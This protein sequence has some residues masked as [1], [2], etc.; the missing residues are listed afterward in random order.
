MNENAQPVFCK[1]YTVPYG[2]RDAV[3]KELD[4]LVEND[5]LYP[6]KHSKIASPIVIVIKSNGSIRICVD[7][8]RTINRFIELE[9]YPLPLIDDIFAN[10]SKCKNFCVLD[11]TGAYQQLAVSERSQEFLTINTHKGLYR[12]KRLVFGVASAPA[13]FQSFMDELLK[14]LENVKCYFD[15][16]CIGGKDFDECKRNLELVLDRFEKNNVRVNMDKCKFYRAT[17]EY[18]GHIISDGSL[19]P[20]D[21]KVEAVLNA[22]PP[23]NVSQLQSF[24]GMIN[25]YAKF[26]PNLSSVLFPLYGLLKKGIHFDWNATHNEAFEKC[27]QL[28]V[29]NNV[30][31]LYDPSKPIIISCD[32]SPYG[33]GCVLSQIF[34]KIEKPVLFASSTLSPAEKNY[35]QVHREA[36]AVVFAVKK[37]HKYVYGKDSRS[38]RIVKLL[39]RFLAT[40]IFHRLLPL[41]C[42]VG[43]FF[44]R[45]INTKWSTKVHSICVMRMGCLDCRYRTS[46]KLMVGQLIYLI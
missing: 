13:I 16:V 34:D 44:F 37:F 24:I 25:Y 35:S 12:S 33:L 27:K 29:S 20:N 17:I 1:P 46:L 38:D 28:L 8:S 10:L 23:K 11:L 39:E 4:R 7:C 40:R 43:V 15:D 6:V 2:V 14:G 18:L 32:A 26:I 30:L 3:E 22:T 41:V 31:A 36:L 19:R 5:I 45:C 42:S 9:H 21:K